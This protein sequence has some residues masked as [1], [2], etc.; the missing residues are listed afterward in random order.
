MLINNV[1]I[2]TV[3]YGSEAFGGNDSRLQRIK[4]VIDK[5]LGHIVHCKNYPRTRVYEELDIKPVLLRASV[6]R[7]RGYIKWKQSKSIIKKL[8]ESGVDFKTRKSTWC[9]NT[10]KW[11]K[12]FKINNNS[13]I[14]IAK[15]EVTEHMIKRFR[16]NDVTQASTFA[17]NLNIRSSKAIRKLQ[18]NNLALNI[19]INELIKIRTGT[20]LSTNRLVNYGKIDR[21]FYNKCI[22]CLENVREDAKHL[23]LDCSKFN[24]ERKIYLKLDDSAYNGLDPPWRS[25]FNDTLQIILGG[26]CP[27]SGKMPSESIVNSINFLSVISKRRKAIIG[28]CLR[29]RS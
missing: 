29:R 21:T 25:N 20:C 2:P 15:E 6:N 4:T 24:N 22:C 10:L 27:A 28:E 13:D 14:G 17:Y 8:I 12:R 26:E 1:I 16:K 7:V 23:F 5:S 19:G 18:L 3:S 11:M 9:K